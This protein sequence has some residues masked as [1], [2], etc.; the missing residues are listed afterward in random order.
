[1]AFLPEFLSFCD[2]TLLKEVQLKTP[3]R[4]MTASPVELACFDLLNQKEENVSELEDSFSEATLLL[5]LV[6][7][8]EKVAKFGAR[9]VQ[10]VANLILFSKMELHSEVPPSHDKFNGLLSGGIYGSDD[11]G[12]GPARVP[13]AACV[14]SAL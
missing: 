4:E 6:L 1:M 14:V 5:L 11:P 9:P 10:R 12:K 8:P 13:A 3:R 2:Q 7:N